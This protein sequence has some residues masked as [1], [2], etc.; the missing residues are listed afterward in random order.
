[1]VSFVLF[2]SFV[3]KA[4]KSL[5][6]IIMMLNLPTILPPAIKQKIALSLLLS[7]REHQ[8]TAIELRNQAYK[9]LGL[10][11]PWPKPAEPE[12]KLTVE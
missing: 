10:K 8:H 11:A 12:P 3:V 9:L 6:A 2:V 7:A 1:L 5:K 4:L